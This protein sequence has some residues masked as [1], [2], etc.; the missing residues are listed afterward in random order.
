MHIAYIRHVGGMV[1]IAVPFL[2]YDGPPE[3]DGKTRALPY[4]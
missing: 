3:T 4:G 2:T 1:C